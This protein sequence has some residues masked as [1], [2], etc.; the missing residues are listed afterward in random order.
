MKLPLEDVVVLDL[1]HALAGPH[2]ST[3]LAD[4]GAQVY[5]LES[6]DGGDISRAW[7]AAAG[8]SGA[9]SAYFVS[10]HRNKRGLSINLK[11]PE[12][13]ELF[14]KVAEKADVI[15]E[16]F[17]PGALQKLGLGYQAVS[18]RNPG[19]IYASISGF[20]QDGPYRERAAMDL[21][22]QAESGMI[23][24][25]GEEGGSGV[26]C[27]TSIA[28]MAAGMYAAYGI[29]LALRVK[30]K[31]GE[32]QY[33][34]MS[35]MEG[36]LGLL[37]TMIASYGV[38]RELPKPM[39][40][41]YKAL[42]PYQTLRTKTRDLAIAVGSEKLWKVFCPAIGRPEMLTNPRFA[43]NRLRVTHREELIGIVQEA[44]L[45]RSYEEWEQIFLKAGIP[46]GAVNNIGQVVDHPQVK[47]RGSLMEMN[48]PRSGPVMMAGPPV[49]LS[50][51]PG[52]VR[53][54]A[55]GLGEHTAEA[56]HDL[57]GIPAE[58]VARLAKAG[59][60]VTG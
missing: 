58:E 49:R 34:D 48:H 31:T 13:K 15:I 47:A 27:G 8:N 39:G 2:C 9:E 36:Q 17:R 25:T 10:L 30:D 43:D 11:D 29:M 22:L 26:R 18:A 56:L 6:P 54:P 40:T 5:K 50:R 42:L 33:I 3:M 38:D 51:T 14:M 35:M 12:G 4:F 24:I 20:G 1:S 45:T 16:N 57:L 19:I 41:A 23:S 28:D 53:T 37:N 7:G 44:L 55:P 32:G 21:I 59:V 52:S 60:V 46:V